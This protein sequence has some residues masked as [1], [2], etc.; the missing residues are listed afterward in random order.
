MPLP[1]IVPSGG[2]TLAGAFVPAG[3]HVGVNAYHLHR[4]ASIFGA[5]VAT[6][7][8]ERW[9]DADA[10]TARLMAG[11]LFQFGGGA[12]VCIGRNISL[13]EMRCALPAL[14]RRYR[15]E[16]AVDAPKP[17]SATR[18]FAYLENVHVRLF[19]RS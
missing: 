9:L 18:W 13:L 3:T 11:K 2:A 17:R 10:D 5:D 8:P 6:F 7:R 15:F 16:L 14:L 4:Q 19:R 1:R 12:H